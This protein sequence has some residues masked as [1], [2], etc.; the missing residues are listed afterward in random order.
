M[1]ESLL[2]SCIGALGAGILGYVKYLH[3][4]IAKMSDELDTVYNK[5]ETEHL[6]DLK[7]KPV[8]DKT[9]MLEDRLGRLERNIDRILEALSRPPI[10]N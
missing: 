7:L 4:Q 9:T 1:V 2:Y 3:S 10:D 8:Y 6:I 5:T